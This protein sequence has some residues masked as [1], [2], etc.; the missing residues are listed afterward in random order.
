MFLITNDEQTL[1]C[2]SDEYVQVFFSTSMTLTK[3]LAL[4]NLPSIYILEAKWRHPTLNIVMNSLEYCVQSFVLSS[5][6][7][8]LLTYVLAIA[9][10][11]CC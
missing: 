3:A 2:L 4:Y 11:V 10:C 8:D 5:V 6:V 1:K 9:I 7:C